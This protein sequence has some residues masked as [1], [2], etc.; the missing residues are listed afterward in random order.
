VTGH[1][2]PCGSVGIGVGRGGSVGSGGVLVDTGVGV[3]RSDEPGAV[4]ALVAGG[5]VG[6]AVGAGDGVAVR[7]WRVATGVA[8]AAGAPDVGWAELLVGVTSG[9]AAPVGEELPAN[10]RRPVSRV[11]LN[12]ASTRPTARDGPRRTYNVKD[13][14]PPWPRAR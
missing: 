5:A 6:A 9:D 13:A 10:G 14:R 11:R 7:V 2:N 1:G 4:G 3:G 12:P 8:E